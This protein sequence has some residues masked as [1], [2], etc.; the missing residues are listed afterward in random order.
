MQHAPY[1][2]EVVV[3]GKVQPSR[4]ATIDIDAAPCSSSPPA[5]FNFIPATRVGCTLC[6][7]VQSPIYVSI[8][9]DTSKALI[10]ELNAQAPCILSVRRFN[11]NGSTAN[12][13]DITHLRFSS[14]ILPSISSCSTPDSSRIFI[15]T[16]DG[17]LHAITYPEN[18]SGDVEPLTHALNPTA[19]AVQS[20]SL[21]A[22]FEK[23]G[24]P[25]SL[26]HVEST[27]CIGTALGHVLCIPITTTGPL[28]A[29]AL[30][31][32]DLNP[33]SGLLAAVIPT[34]IQNFF[35][36]G[37]Q[38]VEE[39]VELRFLDKPFLCSLH[40]GAVLKLW[41][42]AAKKLVHSCDLLP[43]Q[44]GNSHRAA[45]ARVAGKLLVSLIR[46]SFFFYFLF[47]SIVFLQLSLWM[48]HVPFSLSSSNLSILQF[49]A[50]CAPLSCF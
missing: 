41:D 39:L 30:A 9:Q 49:P 11:L 34:T 7:N 48:P 6:H 12:D 5:Q 18:E 35:S 24:D 37:P 1:A 13:Q 31:A 28:T 33:A 2:V 26:V 4:V 23:L 43:P 46:N 10:W 3:T 29:D 50:C 44:E 25:T 27:V 20:V 45:L 32:F 38:C 21:A 42:L 16:A 17:T 8:P 36:R 15:L 19:G 14:P 40:S 22:F 47:L